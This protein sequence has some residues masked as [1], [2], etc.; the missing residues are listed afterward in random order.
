MRLAGATAPRAGGRGGVDLEGGR[1]QDDDIQTT[2]QRGER[3]CLAVW[4][5]VSYATTIS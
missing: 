3:R 4:L 5:S 1:A 2:G